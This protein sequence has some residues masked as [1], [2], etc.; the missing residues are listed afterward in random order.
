MCV[1]QTA[2]WLKK[3]LIELKGEA[4]TATVLGDFSVPLSQ[5]LTEQ[6]SRNPACSTGT[7]CRRQPTGASRHVQDTQQQLNIHCF[8]EPI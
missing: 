7:W 1:Q 2:Q 8:Q 4:D 3:K 6:P 5:Q